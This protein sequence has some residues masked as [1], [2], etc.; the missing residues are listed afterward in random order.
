[1]RDGATATHCVVV[2]LAGGPVQGV[3]V[4]LVPI[5]TTAVAMSHVWMLMIVT[6]MVAGWEF[7]AQRQTVRCAMTAMGKKDSAL[8]FQTSVHVTQNVE[9]RARTVMNACQTTARWKENA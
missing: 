4:L 6:V 1:M 9:T 2:K 8:L 5:R 7:P 3:K